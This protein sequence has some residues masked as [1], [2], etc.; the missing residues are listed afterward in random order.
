M[1]EP[2]SANLFRQQVRHRRQHEDDDGEQRE[3]PDLKWFAT[4]TGCIAAKHTSVRSLC[5]RVAIC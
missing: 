2:W 4:T 3:V 1:C 5:G